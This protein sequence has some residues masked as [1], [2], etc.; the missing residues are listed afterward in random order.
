V[1]PAALG[2]VSVGYATADGTAKAG[3]DYTATSGTLTLGVGE[4]SRSITIPIRQDDEVEGSETFGVS[5]SDP[6]GDAGL[7]QQATTTV[8]IVNTT[9]GQALVPPEDDT[10]KPRNETEEQRQQRER[11]NRSNKDD[12]HTEG[13]VVEVHQDERPPYVVI[14][15]RDG[16]QRVNLLCG[17]QCPRIEVGTYLEADGE[18][19]HEFLFEATDVTVT[20]GR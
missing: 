14:A 18:K 11:T 20:C 8:T 6:T 4:T 16:L 7:G 12:V 15:T 19:Q 2:S 9:I 13:N 17:D 1:R 3:Q 10:D 5:L